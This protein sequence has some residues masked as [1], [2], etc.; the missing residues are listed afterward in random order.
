MGNAVEVIE[1]SNDLWRVGLAPETGGAI[2]YGKVRVTND[3]SAEAD[4]SHSWVDVLRPTPDS[5]TGEWWE[6]ASYPLIPWSNRIRHGRLM[7]ENVTYQLRRWGTDD[8]AMHGTTV[9]YPWAIAD[10]ATD[11]LTLTFD[12]RAYYG[13]NF[14]W[15]FVARVEYALDG[16]RF[17]CRTTI[18]NVDNE[19]FPCGM[20]H[21]PY[22]VRSL[23]LPTDAL[24]P[25]LGASPVQASLGDAVRLQVNCEASYPLTN[26]M[27]DGPSGPLPPVV[28][29]RQSR[30]LGDALVDDCLTARSGPIAATLDYPGAFTLELEADEALSHVV[31]YIPVGKPY[32]AVEPVTN[33]N[34]A[35]TLH[36][37]GIGGTGV[38]TI[39]PGKS[40]AATFS[41][42]VR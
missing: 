22:F 21:H 37:L 33:A 40:I 1:I 6:S 17:T 14:P 13:V 12:S 15:G 8:F 39:A 25:S 28:D 7:W 4:S 31:V 38:L 18:D 5:L 2:T 24:E 41:L 20:G 19:T 16:P 11:H 9:E 35:F 3:H 10:R 36:A 26:G 42:V 23:A 30:P 32:F 34:D 29:F 27:P